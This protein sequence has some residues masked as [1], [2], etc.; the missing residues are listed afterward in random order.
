MTARANERRNIVR[1]DKGLVLGGEELLEVVRQKTQ[2]ASAEQSGA[3]ETQ[4]KIEI[5]RIVAAVSKVKGEPWEMY[6]DRRGDWGRA[7]VLMVARRKAGVANEVLAE[8][9]GGKHGSAVTQAVKRLEARLKEDRKLT[10]I[11]RQVE[12]EMSNVKM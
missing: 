10:K 5:I 1:G 4:P 7:M 2:G 12:I 8:W 3:R 11:H 9:L 6:R